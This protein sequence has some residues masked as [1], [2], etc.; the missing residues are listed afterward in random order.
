[1]IEQETHSVRNEGRGKGTFPTALLLC[2]FGHSRTMLCP[3]LFDFKPL[4]PSS[5]Q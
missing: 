4:G 1:M 2:L 5:A 3:F